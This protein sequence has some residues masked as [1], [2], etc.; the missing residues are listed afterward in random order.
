MKSFSKYIVTKNQLHVVY[1]MWRVGSCDGKC[2]FLF[3]LSPEYVL[4]LDLC[5][6]GSDVMIQSDVSDKHMQISLHN[7]TRISSYVSV[8]S[9]IYR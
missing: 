5:S 3:E 8:C 6:L 4:S 2:S 1:Q 9:R 7:T